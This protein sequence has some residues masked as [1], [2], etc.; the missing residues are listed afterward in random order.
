MSR[1][2][3]EGGVV[4]VEHALVHVAVL[5]NACHE[6]PQTN[7]YENALPGG[8][9]YLVPHLLVQSVELLYSLQV[10]QTR[11]RVG[12]GPYAQVVHLSHIGPGV[13]EG[14]LQARLF[15]LVLVGSLSVAI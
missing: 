2:L 10:V 9:G 11:G 6:E 4:A 8:S 5:G 7:H 12:Q 15:E 14:G 1:G 13:L 3:P